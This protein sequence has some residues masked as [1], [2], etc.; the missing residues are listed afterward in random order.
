M[1]GNFHI[2]NI[3]V[4]AGVGTPPLDKQL[5]RHF[6]MALLDST[7][8]YHGCTWLYL[9][10]LHSTMALLRS[11]WLYY[12]NTVPSLYHILPWLYCTLPWVYLALLGSTTLYHGYTTFYRG[13]IWLY[14]TLHDSISFHNSSTWLNERHWSAKPS[15]QQCKL[16]EIWSVKGSGHTFVGA[17]LP[18]ANNRIRKERLSQEQNGRLPRGPDSYAC[19][20][21]AE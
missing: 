15:A 2:M 18:M 7:T 16:D 10:L 21:A 17:I 9:T 5:L 6:N 12:C 1:C 8:S 13:S 11:T 20:F 3:D 19:A 14:L 4:P